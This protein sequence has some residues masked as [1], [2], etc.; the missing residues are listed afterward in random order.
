MSS[1]FFTTYIEFFC[2]QLATKILG[3][4]SNILPLLTNRNI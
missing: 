3:F 4:L 2:T 1:G